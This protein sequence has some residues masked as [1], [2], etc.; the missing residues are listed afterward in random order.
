MG[1][2]ANLRIER[3]RKEAVRP[4][5]GYG[6]FYLDFYGKFVSADPSLSLE[7]RDAGTGFAYDR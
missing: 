4:V 7:E 3:L 6:R 1:G 5:I 2:P